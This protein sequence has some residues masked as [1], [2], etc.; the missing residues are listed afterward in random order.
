MSAQDPIVSVVIPTFNRAQV[1]CRAIQSVIDQSFENYEIIVVDDG[2]TDNTADILKRK[3]NGSISVIRNTENNGGSYARNI[4][5]RNSKGKY[6]ALLD[7]DDEWLPTKLEKQIAFFEVCNPAVGVVYCL[8]FEKKDS[9]KKYYLN[10]EHGQIHKTLLNGWCPSITSSV[11]IRND[12]FKQG[13]LFDEDL[14][15]FQDYDLWIRIAK[16][17]EFEVLREHLVINHQ[18]QDNRVSID[19]ALRLNG[20]YLFLK[21]WG[22]AIHEIGGYPAVDFF[23]R[24]YLSIAYS[25]AALNKLRQHE[26][27]AAISFFIK[28]LKTRRIKPKFFFEFLILFLC[29]EKLI[30][31]AANLHKN[32][33]E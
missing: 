25:Q 1:I 11:L 29:N 27:R 13:N 4:G 24:K 22:D 31:T 32:L 19:I 21:K 18:H 23:R 15:S 14:T 5:I 10:I 16:N 6:I 20:L 3:W 8:Y 9:Y 2:S 12:V 17:W 7:S 28:L 26:K 30:R 33:T